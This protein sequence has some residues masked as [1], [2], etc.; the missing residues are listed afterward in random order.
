V[1]IPTPPVPKH[2]DTGPWWPSPWGAD[3]QL[4]AL[5]RVTSESVL[6]FNALVHCGQQLGEH[7]DARTIHY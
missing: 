6:H 4:G 2:P 7:G 3:D 1:D 5:N